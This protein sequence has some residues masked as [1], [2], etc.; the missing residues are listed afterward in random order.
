[1]KVI[2]FNTRNFVLLFTAFFYNSILFA[3]VGIGTN[4]P[5]TSTI[6]DIRSSTKGMLIPRI[7]EY[8]RS[9]ITLTAEG[10]LVQDL[11]T[12]KTL[13]NRNN[14][15]QW[16]IV[17]PA[18]NQN[19]KFAAFFT[20]NSVHVLNTV[21]QSGQ[22]WSDFP[23]SSTILGFCSSENAILFHTASHA[24]IIYL[25]GLSETQFS[26]I[27][28]SGGTAASIDMGVTGT[29][30][31][32]MIKGNTAYRF[33]PVTGTW[34]TTALPGSPTNLR[35][36]KDFIIFTA[37]GNAYFYFKQ[38]S[39]SSPISGSRAAIYSNAKKNVA[40]INTTTNLYSFLLVDQ[41]GATTM[42]VLSNNLTSD[43]TNVYDMDESNRIVVQTNDKLWDFNY[44][45]WSSFTITGPV[46]KVVAAAAQ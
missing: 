4:N 41:F 21:S 39:N 6:L 9:K 1:M 8:Q 12:G 28:L 22:T 24:Y 2:K 17:N 30:L 33:S 36:L 42:Q 5:D 31:A 43:V 26:S 20:D 45:A 40:I 27:A 3:Q 29:G 7:T 19:A 18:I 16:G 37:G 23:V 46:I 25:D 15:G 14:F 10:L 34:S 38:F 35:V 13:T 32:V 44:N 11:H